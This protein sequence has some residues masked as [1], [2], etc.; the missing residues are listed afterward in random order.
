MLLLLLPCITQ[1]SDYG[2]DGHASRPSPSSQSSSQQDAEADQTELKNTCC[3][4]KVE[5]F[6]AAVGCDA[7][8]HIT[9]TTGNS[10]EQQHQQQEAIMQEQQPAGKLAGGWPTQTGACREVDMLA[11][12]WVTA[13]QAS[14]PS[15]N[16]SKLA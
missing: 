15:I 3:D 13:A 8:V 6:S 4:L 1:A 11:K 5:P 9:T 14:Q 7:A 2:S 12:R 10:K 16:H